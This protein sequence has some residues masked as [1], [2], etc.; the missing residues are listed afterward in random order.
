[1]SF[2]TL[3]MHLYKM[4]TFRYD[5]A[6]CSGVNKDIEIFLCFRAVIALEVVRHL[7]HRESAWLFLFLDVDNL[8][9]VGRF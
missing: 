2:S 4:P 8:P 5:L 9:I 1:M 3:T 6:T 7:E